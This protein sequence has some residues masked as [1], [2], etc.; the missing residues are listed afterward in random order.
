M[1]DRNILIIKTTWSYTITQPDV[2]GE[3][4]YQK[5]FEMDPSLKSMFPND[6]DAQIQKLI[7]MITYMVTHLQTMQDIQKQIDAMAIRHAGYGVKKEHYQLVGTALLWML[8]SRLDE[9]WNDEAK[10]AW[11]SLYRLWSTSMINASEEFTQI[12]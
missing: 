5:L 8:E 6:M 9:L 3:L 4:F 1:T 10:D 7:D 12:K 2:A 11:T